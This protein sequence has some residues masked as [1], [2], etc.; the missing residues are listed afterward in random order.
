[1]VLRFLTPFVPLCSFRFPQ[2][3]QGYGQL[4]SGHCEYRGAFHA[5]HMHGHGVVQVRGERWGRDFR[6][7]GPSLVALQMEH[8]EPVHGL[9]AENAVS[10]SSSSSSPASADLQGG[11]GGGGVVAVW[12]AGSPELV[13]CLVEQ[14]AKSA[15]IP[16]TAVAPHSCNGNDS[17]SSG[18]GSSRGGLESPS[19][20]AASSSSSSL[21]SSSSSPTWPSSSSEVFTS[22]AEAAARD[23]AWFQ[24]APNPCVAYCAPCKFLDG[25]L[26]VVGDLTPIAAPAASSALASN[27]NDSSSSENTNSNNTT[28]DKHDENAKRASPTG[29][30]DFLDDE[31]LGAQSQSSSSSPKP[32]LASQ[33]AREACHLWH[34]QERGISAKLQSSAHGSVGA[35]GGASAGE[36]GIRAS[37]SFLAPVTGAAAEDLQA[38]FRAAL[39]LKLSRKRSAQAAGLNRVA[40]VTSEE[41]NVLEKLA[42]GTP[43]TA[44]WGNLIQALGAWGWTY[45]TAKFP[46]TWEWGLQFKAKQKT[47]EGAI[48]KAYHKSLLPTRFYNDPNPCRK[49]DASYALRQHLTAH[50]SLW[51]LVLQ[52]PHESDT[53]VDLA[54][55]WVDTY[56]A[57]CQSALLAAAVAEASGEGGQGGPG[58]VLATAN[59]PIFVEAPPAKRS[60]RQ[61]N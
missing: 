46:Y 11:S 37:F 34:A 10:S 13:E 17:N 27:S 32:S 4:E 48:G 60:C 50:P 44:D 36:S 19:A 55:K 15:P 57:S 29:V 54:R 58:G 41:L 52:G 38:S 39:E 40:L 16:V 7:L 2:T 9:T 45:K 56:N 23:A 25:K 35:S 1:M 8:G 6:R 3:L 22:E 5:N 47:E 30:A 12:A 59:E 20:A 43:M 51:A 31:L 49:D 14:H 26:V 53:P 28:T 21:S 24:A 33:A 61:R 42:Q 18:G